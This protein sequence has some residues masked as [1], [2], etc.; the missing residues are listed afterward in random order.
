MKNTND[1]PVSTGPI[2]INPR[3]LEDSFGKPKRQ[4]T[5]RA[6]VI[7]D[8]H[9][10]DGV[11]HD[12]VEPGTHSLA[13][14]AHLAEVER[15]AFLHV[16]GD[17]KQA[18]PHVAAARVLLKSPAF[19]DLPGVRKYLD[20]VSK[21]HEIVPEPPEGERFLRATRRLPITLTVKALA[22]AARPLV[23]MAGKA[24]AAAGHKFPKPTLVPEPGLDTEPGEFPAGTTVEAKGKA[25]ASLFPGVPGE[26]HEPLPPGVKLT[27]NPTKGIRKARWDAVAQLHA[28]GHDRDKIIRVLKQYYGMTQRAA[29]DSYR[30]FV[31]AL[32]NPEGPERLARP[33]YMS[34]GLPVHEQL[35]GTNLHHVLRSIHDQ[36]VQSKPHVA[37]AAA[38]ALAQRGP[39][40]FHALGAALGRARLKADHPAYEWDKMDARHAMDRFVKNKLDSMVHRDEGDSDRSFYDRAARHFNAAHDNTGEATDVSRR[41]RAALIRHV[42]ASQFA[43]YGHGH[44]DIETAVHDSLNRIADNHAEKEYRNKRGGKAPARVKQLSDAADKMDALV[45]RWTGGHKEAGPDQRRDF[46]RNLLTADPEAL[47]KRG[48][49]KNGSTWVAAQDRLRQHVAAEHGSVENGLAAL[50]ELIAHGTAR[51]V[52]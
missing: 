32:A 38:D 7:P 31:R 14:Q 27:L 30:R 13:P 9:W 35:I 24:L 46:I 17:P 19:R 34:D 29:A 36:Y 25:A 6:S 26:D 50:N 40:P 23:G 4:D 1:A 8:S 49:M 20:Y 16:L 22:E 21:L 10:A 28:A 15:A 48:T 44:P 11:V 39:S 33:T 42:A 43:K 18:Q 45:N 51:R 5:V 3:T 12:G 47:K 2:K 41:F 37:Q 52:G